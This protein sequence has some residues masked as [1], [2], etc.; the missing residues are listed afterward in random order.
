MLGTTLKQMAKSVAT[1]SVWIWV[2]K[3]IEGI[4]HLEWILS[5]LKTLSR[6]H[7]LVCSLRS[8]SLQV[9]DTVKQ[10]A[11]HGNVS[12]PENPN[13]IEAIDNLCIS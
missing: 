13:P 12:V 9:S 11:S 10:L 5:Y 6:T 4:K 1:L 8:A 7:D 3:L 2:N